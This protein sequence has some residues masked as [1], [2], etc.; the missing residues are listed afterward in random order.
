MKRFLALLLLTLFSV[1]L[2][3]C[4]TTTTTTLSTSTRT[5][6]DTSWKVVYDAAPTSPDF[7]DNVSVCYQIFPIAWADSNGDGYGDFNGIA[8]NIDYLADTLQVDCIWMNP[9]NPSPSYHKYDVTNFYEVDPQFGTMADLEH[10]LSVAHDNGIRVLMD[11]VINHTAYTHPWFVNSSMGPSS[12][13]RDF[14]VWNDLKDRA[15]FPSRSAWYLNNGSYYFASFWSQMPELN[16]DNQAV[17][18]EIKA[19]A[20]FWLNKGIDGFRI[21]AAKHIYDTAEYAIGTPTLLENINWFK[22]FNDHVKSIDPDALVLGEVYVL[23]SAF[24]AN[25][26]E[27]MDSAFNFDFADKLIYSAIAGYDS[28]ALSSL[29]AGREA[30]ALKR[31]DPIDSLFLTNHDQDR[32]ADRLGHNPDKLKLVN[33]VLMTMPGIAWIYYG[34]ELGM[35]G[36]KPDSQIR[37]PFKWDGERS[38]YVTSAK[39]NGIAAWTTYN[40]SL[41]GVDAQL[42]VGSGSILESYKTIIGLRQQNE[43]LRKGDLVA[44]DNPN[45]RLMAY[46]RTYEG[47][48]YLVIHNFSASSQT[49]MHNLTTMN[50]VWTSAPFDSSENVLTISP[51]QTAIFAI[52]NQVVVLRNPT[53]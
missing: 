26:Y 40:Q 31:T 13:Y 25:Y 27:G 39:P 45:N 22:E 1:S 11:Y 35:S 46:T 47:V 37:Q 7:K 29:I 14:Y 30:F 34:E 20:T 53:V 44:A 18:T 36:V 32:V 52:D 42:I 50:L 4:Q 3:A 51:Y 10:L 41:L 8:E 28:T 6:R 33:R 2:A 9:F 43:V 24:V 15:A 38:A 21:D 12:S 23:S 5:T 16:Y 49:T 17:R 19:I 48:T